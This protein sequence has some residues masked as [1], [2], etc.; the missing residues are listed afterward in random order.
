MR[1][2]LEPRRPPRMTATKSR[3]V[4]RRWCAGSMTKQKVGCDPCCDARP[5]LSAPHGYAC[6][7][8][9][10]DSSPADDDSAGTCAS[11]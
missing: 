2:V 11:W 3:D 6:E 8:G 4:R 10:H 5:G 9:T 7:P 1:V